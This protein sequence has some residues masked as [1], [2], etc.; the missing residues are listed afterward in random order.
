MIHFPQILE[1]VIHVLC[2]DDAYISSVILLLLFGAILLLNG[3]HIPDHIG[4][5]LL[6]PLHIL[7]W[8]LPCVIELV[9]GVVFVVL[10]IDI[11]LLLD[12][13]CFDSSGLLD[14]QR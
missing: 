8:I 7:F 4:I 5:F 3:L 2:D 14:G 10:V 12:V 13:V 6:Y 9:F 11:L 1:D